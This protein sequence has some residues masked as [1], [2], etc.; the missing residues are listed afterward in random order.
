M[1]CVNPFITNDGIS[2]RCGKCYPCQITRIQSW[3]YR[4]QQQDRVSLTSHF[5]TL[6]YNTDNVPIIQNKWPMTL[7]KKDLQDYFKRLRK[8]APNLKYMAASE[9]GGL[10][11]RPHYHAIIYNA[12]ELDI[13]RAWAIDG[14]AI[15]D[16]FLGKVT[17][18][19]IAYCFK[20][21]QKTKKVPLNQY[22]NRERERAFYS[23]GLG[24][25]WV[26]SKQSEYHFYNGQVIPERGY[27]VTKSGHKIAMP[28]YYKQKQFTEE[29]RMEINIAAEEQAYQN[30]LKAM[31]DPNYYIIKSAK[32][33]ADF[34]IRKKIEKNNEIS[35]KIQ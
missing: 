31:Q 16:V 11:W 4:L 22:D 20:Y 2:V 28:R 14:K 19:S 1:Q 32:R 17:E 21:L 29:Q 6:T 10:K 8:R 26:N 35:S 27:L 33:I 25:N 24:L 9:Y 18:E 3:V 7:R 13:I 34:D 5:V 30:E 15:G 23:K 12:H